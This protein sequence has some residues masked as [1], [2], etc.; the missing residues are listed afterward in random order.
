MSSNHSKIKQLCINNAKPGRSNY[1]SLVIH[2]TSDWAAENIDH[3]REGLTQDLLHH[4]S[5]IFQKD[6]T[7]AEYQ[8]LHA[9][10]YATSDDHGIEQYLLDSKL[11]LAACGDWCLNGDVESAFLSGHILAKELKK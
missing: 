4:C 5:P 8:S 6:L 1:E 7:Q 9:W 3:D 11:S 10:R 2:T